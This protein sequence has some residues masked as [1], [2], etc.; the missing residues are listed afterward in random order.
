MKFLITEQQVDKIVESILNK[1]MPKKFDW[2]KGLK[3]VELKRMNMRPK[4]VMLRGK[5]TVDE[6]WA[7]EQCMKIY[8]SK[9]IDFNDEIDPALLSQIVTGDEADNIR[10]EISYILT[11]ITGEDTFA[12]SLN[13]IEIKLQHSDDTDK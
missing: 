9:I 2:W 10:D 12:P 8:D 13:H 6:E 3:V 5:L 7:G 1:E 11:F 4:L